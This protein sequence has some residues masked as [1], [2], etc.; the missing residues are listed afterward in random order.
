M[1]RATRLV[2]V[3]AAALVAVAAAAPRGQQMMEPANETRP[4][5]KEAFDAAAADGKTILVDFYA[6]WCPVCRA[7][8]PKVKARLNADFKHVVAFRVDYDSNAALRKAMNVQKQSTLILFQGR[9]ELARLSYTSD[10]KAID[11]L[12]AHAKRS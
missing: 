8:E 5:T 1:F 2:L 12:F 4:F 11:E 10:D 3:C 9:N 7:Q 6:P